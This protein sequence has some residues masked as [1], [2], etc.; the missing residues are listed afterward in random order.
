MI[1]HRPKTRV[2]GVA[3]FELL[4]AISTVAVVVM[5]LLPANQKARESANSAACQSTMRRLGVAFASYATDFRRYPRRIASGDPFWE[6]QAGKLGLHFG[7][8]GDTL[9]G[10]GYEF[11]YAG[12]KAIFDLTAIPAAP[13]LTASTTQS[14]DERAV[15][16]DSGVIH[17][18][19]TEVPTPGADGNRDRAFGVIR[20]CGKATVAQLLLKHG[21]AEEAVLVKPFVRGESAAAFRDLDSDGDG[22]VTFVEIF[23]GK[24]KQVSEQLLS[25]IAR[26]LQLGAGG[27]R[28]KDLPGVTLRDLAGNP[29]DLFS[30]DEVCHSSVIATDKVGV[31]LA[32]CRKLDAA[33]NAESRGKF[34]TRNNILRSYQSLVSAQGGKAIAEDLA[35][36]LVVLAQILK[37]PKQ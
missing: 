25:C 13:G 31:A 29:E 9:I 19:V 23:Q 5:G 28:V 35:D 20:E 26:Q 33:G 14:I 11:S 22:L 37:S 6:A 24:N 3:L 21:S 2:K 4:I 30:F 17:V 32:S 7:P 10:T 27:E 15:V 18:E 34:K 36:V 8:N 12:G 1:Q 16:V